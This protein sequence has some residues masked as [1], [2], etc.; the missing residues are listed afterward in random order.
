MK[1]YGKTAAAFI[2]CGLAALTSCFYNPTAG[3]S[4]TYT[5][6]DISLTMKYVP[7]SL[8]CPTGVAD[9]GTATVSDAYW[10]ADTE[11]TY[12]LWSTVYKWATG[13][14]NMN[15]VIDSGE[16]AGQYT[17][18][19]YGYQGIDD[20]YQDAQYGIDPMT[21]NQHPVTMVSWRDAMVFCNALTE[22]LNSR[23][24]CAALTAWLNEVNKCV[25]YT[26]SSFTTPIRSVNALEAVDTTAG[27]Q[28]N[29]YVNPDARGF[30]LPSS[31]E[32][33]VAA[34]YV[35]GSA[36]LYG[37]HASGDASGPCFL[38]GSATGLGGEALST[39]FGNYAVSI[40]NSGWSTAAVKSKTANALGLYDMSGNVTEWCF[41][42]SVA[43]ASR[44]YRGGDWGD[45]DD[46]LRVG[47]TY[48]QAPYEVLMTG[49]FRLTRNVVL[50]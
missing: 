12:Q 41:D 14:A 21:T 28:D 7:G 20:I 46:Y 30:R 17:F 43:N 47:G 11:V 10:V 39:V 50:Q 22:W 37:D 40:D 42:W 27:S 26:D 13:D 9:S 2:L 15:G 23:T 49:G 44:L 1:T 32:W 31:A 8:T 19:D 35:D 3:D 29:P 45:T 38:K 5:V 33:E 16:T 4:V 18:A 25:Y 6:D 34:R 36:W 24:G 48:G